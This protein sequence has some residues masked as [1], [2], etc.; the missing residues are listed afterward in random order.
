MLSLKG[1]FFC[2]CPLGAFLRLLLKQLALATARDKNLLRARWSGPRWE[3]QAAVLPVP[4]VPPCSQGGWGCTMVIS[5]TAAFQ[6]LGQELRV[7]ARGH[8]V[9]GKSLAGPPSP[10]Q[11]SGDN[12]LPSGASCQLDPLAQS[13]DKLFHVSIFHLKCKLDLTE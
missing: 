6:L 5:H 9:L 7:E 2:N 10:P 3:L 8:Q 13:G 4:W 11:G 1:E 12:P